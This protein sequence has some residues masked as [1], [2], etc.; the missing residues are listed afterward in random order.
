MFGQQYRYKRVP[1]GIKSAP[2]LFQRTIN[3]ILEGIDN[4]IIYIDNIVIYGSNELK[5]NTTLIEVLKRLRK[6]EVKINFDKSKFFTKKLE[7][8]GS[9]IENGEIR[10]DNESIDKLIAKDF[11]ANSKKDIQKIIGVVT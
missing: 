7:I 6:Y 1:F 3:K 10:I 8:L 5:H 2:K 4:C 9:I 11:K